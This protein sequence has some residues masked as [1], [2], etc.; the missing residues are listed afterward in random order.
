MEI[1][2]YQITFGEK[3]ETPAEKIGARVKMFKECIEVG[4]AAEAV[5]TDLV[6][7]FPDVATEAVQEMRGDS[8]PQS[9]AFDTITMQTLPKKVGEQT[10]KV[11]VD[12]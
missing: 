10:F 7:A 6:Q 1:F 12:R 5:T 4:K 8:D 2:G 9:A 11:C 3:V